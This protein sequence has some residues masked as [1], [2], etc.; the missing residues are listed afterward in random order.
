MVTE[1]R[2]YTVLLY[3]EPEDDGFSVVIPSLPGCVTQGETIEES[4]ANAREAITV[5]LRSLAKHGEEIPVEDEPPVVASVIV[6]APAAV[7]A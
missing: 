2:R 5:Y 6:E 3:H 1:T 7:P 4:L